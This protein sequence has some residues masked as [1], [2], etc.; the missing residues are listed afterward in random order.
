MLHRVLN[1]TAWFRLWL[2]RKCRRLLLGPV[3]GK[4]PDS[5]IHS[6]EESSYRED[7]QPHF[8]SVQTVYGARIVKYQLPEKFPAWFR[9]EKSFEAK[10][11]YALRDVIVSPCSGLIWSNQGV[12]FG[13]SI[14][15]LYRLLGW[16][17]CLHEPLIPHKVLNSDNP[18]ICCPNALYYHWLLEMLPNILYALD[19]FPDVKILVHT[20]CRPFIREG[21]ELALGGEAY[22]QKIL[23][24]RDKV[25]L[26]APQVIMPALEE[27][28]GYIRPEDVERIRKA[29]KPH[30]SREHATAKQTRLYVSRAHAYRRRLPHEDRIEERL[31][32]AGF[33]IIYPE[34]MMLK[35]QIGIFSRATM[36]VAPHG[37]GL[38]NMVWSTGNCRIGEIFTSEC[39]NDCYA[40][41]AVQLGFDYRYV[42]LHDGADAEET[43]E[44]VLTALTAD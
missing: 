34:E 7:L 13:E 40:R 42:I 44:N 38:S 1:K 23:F 31:Q 37:A 36:I 22:K 27:W 43:A 10:K 14:G 18:V 30:L 12:L 25:P 41:L 33:E 19:L 6:V 39:Q 3:S 21:L 28:S 16:G 15:D 2:D 8:L 26:L 20:E 4:I 32:N 29:F 5:F 17:A 24:T 9:R 35:E 11:I